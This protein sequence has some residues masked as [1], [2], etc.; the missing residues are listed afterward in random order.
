M[1]SIRLNIFSSLLSVLS[2]ICLIGSYSINDSSTPQDKESAVTV[3]MTNTMKFTPDTVRIETGDTVRW[4]NQSLLAH[5]VTGDPSE[6]TVKESVKLP[7]GA[8][9]FNS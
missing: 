5:T 2:L 1:K 7:E 8:E 3:G 6:S 9:P 4:E